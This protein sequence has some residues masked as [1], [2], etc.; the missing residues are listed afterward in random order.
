MPK[1]LCKLLNT[2]PT[3][4][5]GKGV[6]YRR[7]VSVSGTDSPDH[8]AGWGLWPSITREYHSPIASL[9]K[10]PDSNLW[11][12]LNAYCFCTT[13]KKSNNPKWYYCKWNHL[14]SNHQSQGPSVLLMP[15]INTTSQNSQYVRSTK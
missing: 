1:S 11:L 9:G 13:R 2:A 4:K 6:R 14:K 5:S 3:V 15:S 10:D 8:A 12:L 7:R